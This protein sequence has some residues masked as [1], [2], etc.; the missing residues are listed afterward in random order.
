M[1][2][3]QNLDEG[4]G[5]NLE[6]AMQGIARGD[7]DQFEILHK[8]LFNLVVG[9]AYRVLNDRYDAEDVA[10]EVFTNL[11][12]KAQ[13]F[14]SKRGNPKTWL[15]TM[16][17]NRAIDRL[18]SKQ[19]RAQLRDELEDEVQPE[20]IREKQDVLRNVAQDEEAQVLRSAVMKLSLEQREAIEM[21]Y[22]SGYSQSQAAE[23]LRTPLGTVKARIR[24]GIIKLRTMV[25]ELVDED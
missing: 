10:Q 8:E 3:T 7:R 24:R 2:A 4:P 11:W 6:V 5:V 1:K 17:R 9:T 23:R 25:P 12:R 14:D 21:T 13:L 19:R 16:A 15:A 20:M 22:F 18:R